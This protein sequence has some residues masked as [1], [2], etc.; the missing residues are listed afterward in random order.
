MLKTLSTEPSVDPAR[1]Q[2]ET[3][4]SKPSSPRNAMRFPGDQPRPPPNPPLK[5]SATEPCQ[6][7]QRYQ[8][9]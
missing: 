7:Q 2:P 8:Q 5:R 3:K 9:G 6:D 4:P 1:P